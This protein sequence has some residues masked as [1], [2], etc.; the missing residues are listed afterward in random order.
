M[1]WI[2][3][4]SSI[5]VRYSVREL[6]M[7]GSLQLFHDFALRAAE[8]TSNSFSSSP[9]S[10]CTALKDSLSIP[11]TT[12]L[13]AIYYSSPA[14]VSVLGVCDTSALIEAPLCR[15]QFSVDTSNSSNITAEAW[16]PTDWNGRFLA[17]GNGGLGGCK[18][19]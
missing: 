8:T 1:D 18:W 19:Q 10:A 16:L 2:Q 17:L 3:H 7:A 11:N 9:A 12:V 14:N 4:S 6:T 13:D 5:L 15:L